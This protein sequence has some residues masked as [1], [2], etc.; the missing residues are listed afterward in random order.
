M[1]LRHWQLGWQANQELEEGPC[2]IHARAEIGILICEE[3]AI[4]SNYTC[5]S[6]E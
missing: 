5:M 2:S 1:A 6:P 3:L 4:K